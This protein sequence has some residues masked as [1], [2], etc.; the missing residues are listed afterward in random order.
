MARR[1]DNPATQAVGDKRRTGADG[2]PVSYRTQ[3]A[4]NKCKQYFDRRLQA[5][6]G[7]QGKHRNVPLRACLTVRFRPIP[8][9]RSGPETFRNLALRVFGMQGNVTGSPSVSGGHCAAVTSTNCAPREPSVMSPNPTSIA[10]AAAPTWTAARAGNRSSA[11]R[12]HQQLTEELKWW[13][14]GLWNARMASALPP[15]GRQS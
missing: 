11:R 6:G 14:A 8:V 10:R 1:L 7:R 9:P 5:A 13:N 2:R 12:L 15:T 3:T 4:F